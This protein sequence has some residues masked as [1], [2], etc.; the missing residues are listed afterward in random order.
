MHFHA[1]A[2]GEW[3]IR[4]YF[5]SEPVSYEESWVVTRVP[6]SKLREILEGAAAHRA[7]LLQEW[8]EKVLPHG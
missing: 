7:S 6:A 2:P 5:L 3:E 1:S 8:S 4:V